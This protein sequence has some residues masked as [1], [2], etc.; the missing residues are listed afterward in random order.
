MFLYI[1]LLILLRIV[2]S[3]V[4]ILGADPS[5]RKT[6]RRYGEMHVSKGRM[7]SLGSKSTSQAREYIS[8]DK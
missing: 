6:T 3:K 2:P 8:V 5:P 4:Q 1:K 7:Q